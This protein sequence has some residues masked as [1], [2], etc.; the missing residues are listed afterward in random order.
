MTQSN[1]PAFNNVSGRPVLADPVA[2]GWL[3][4]IFLCLTARSALFHGVTLTVAGIQKR[5]MQ[6]PMGTLSCY[7]FVSAVRG[8]PWRTEL[9]SGSPLNSCDYLFQGK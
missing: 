3:F 5:G 4:K 6:F 1:P 7:D 8:L 2:G 9:E